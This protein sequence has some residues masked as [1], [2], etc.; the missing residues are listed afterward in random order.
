MNF[1]T[2][3]SQ[4]SPFPIYVRVCLA[5]AL[6]LSL[7]GIYQRNKVES[8]NKSI[9]ISAEYETIASFSAVQGISAAQGLNSLKMSGLRGVVISDDT[10]ADLENNGLIQVTSLTGEPPM[11]GS[12]G[13]WVVKFTGS[14]SALNR[15]QRG[16]GIRFSGASMKRLADGLVVTGISPAVIGTVSAGLDPNAVADAKAAGLTIIARM[17]NPIGIDAGGTSDMIAWAHDLGAKVFLPEGD[18]V[19]GRRDAQDALITALEANGMY[20]ADPEFTKI[21]GNSQVIVKAPEIVVRLHSAQTAELDKDTPAAAV[22][23][24]VK[25][26]RERNMRILLV[27]QTNEAGPAVL[28]SFGDFIGKIAQ[29]LVKEGDGIGAPRPFTQPAVPKWFYPL[30]GLTL[31]PIVFWLLAIFLPPLALPGAAV[32]LAA[33]VAA[34]SMTERGPIAFLAALAF[35]CLAFLS[36]EAY[37]K[38]PLVWRYV[39]TCLISLCGGF[40][41]AAMLS[42][43]AYY[44]QAVE[45][46]GVKAAVFIPLFIA[47]AYFLRRLGRANERMKEPITYAAV[48]LGFILVVVLGIMYLRTG[49]DNP[50]AVSPLEL[51]MRGLLDRYLPVRPRTK[52]FLVGLPGLWIAL[53]MLE[54]WK[55]MDSDKKKDNFG[56]WTSL[57]VLTAMISQTDIVNTFCHIHTPVLLS[58]E[59]IGVEMVLGAIIGAILLGVWHLLFGRR[60]GQ[61][62]DMARPAET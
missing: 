22:E 36:L 58:I 50:A 2:F 19:L 3:P 18:Q 33:A 42:Q 29:R 6:L 51:H 39:Q 47:V 30:L 26:G 40:F 61:K 45:F 34:Y 24:Y 4:R 11:T 49:N 7:F 16:I 52:S 15:V 5:I 9:C 53:W 21:G 46:H 60:K 23:R 59:R 41:V 54:R 62:P 27:R 14:P 57:A 20:Y 13:S 8:H 31:V 10:V 56:L 28:K 37:D 38:G 1:F 55:K 35:P 25:A 48:L 44:I 12:P 43:L 17:P 32:T